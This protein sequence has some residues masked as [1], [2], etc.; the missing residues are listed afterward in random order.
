MDKEYSNGQME[1]H[2]KANGKIV[3]E[4]DMEAVQIYKMINILV[5]G[6]MIKNM[7]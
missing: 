3:K 5:N 7:E 2:M 4:M 6:K 1:I